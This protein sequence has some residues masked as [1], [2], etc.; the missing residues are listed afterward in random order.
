MRICRISTNFVP[1][2]SGLGPGPYELSRA[3][4]GLGH[5]VTVITLAAP[6]SEVIDRDA[7]FEIHRI[8]SRRHLTFSGRA[9]RLFYR[10][11]RRRP[12]DIIHSHG[13]SAICLMVFR[14]LLRGGPPLVSSVHVVRRTQYRRYREVGRE[15]RA[16]F[17]SGEL[18]AAPEGAVM[19]LGRTWPD[20]LYERLY[21]RLSDALATVNTSLTRDIDTEYGISDKVHTVLNGVAFDAP[22]TDDHGVDRRMIRTAFDCDRLILFVGRIYGGKGEFDLIE[23][24]T[25][26][27][28]QH[29]RAKLLMVGQGPVKTAAQAF[30]ATRGLGEAISFIDYMPQ[31]ELR[32]YF[33]ASD[34]FV[35]PSYSE[36][37]P[38]VLLEAMVSG[39]APVVSD[40]PAHRAILTQGE[41]G[42]LFETGNAERMAEAVIAALADPKRPAVIRRAAEL[43]REKYTWPAVA[44]RLDDI[45]NGLQHN[46]RNR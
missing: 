43:V 31:D 6:G 8:A 46:N 30:A 24:M 38:K 14:T 7:P 32:H 11:H 25:R 17:A 19:A 13:A 12:F 22:N 37:L 20:E 35:L 29:P 18:G 16:R 3:Q 9:A 42:Y 26:V 2:W 27:R 1:P 45:Y 33:A 23:A 41:T 36:G 5:E 34:V 39:A 10:L 21:F 40:I 15:L 44:R 28:E 4:A